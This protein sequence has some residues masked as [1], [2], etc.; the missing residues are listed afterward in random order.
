MHLEDAAKPHSLL[1]S[2]HLRNEPF[3]AVNEVV[4]CW[5][6]T[7]L[8]GESY[9]A[10]MCEFCLFLLLSLSK[11]LSYFRPAFQPRRKVGDLGKVIS[12]GIR[13]AGAQVTQTDLSPNAPLPPTRFAR[14]HRNIEMDIRSRVLYLLPF[15]FV[16]YY[17][18]IKFFLSFLRR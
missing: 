7:A 6:T 14:P 16:V 9:F 10:T 1:Y 4:K 13:L 5:N 3:W 15:S 18:T 12:S 2:I 17:A 8:N 11:M